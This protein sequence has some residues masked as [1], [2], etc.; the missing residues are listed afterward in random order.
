LDP[1]TAE[2]RGL[3]GVEIKK[4]MMWSSRLMRQ[5]GLAEVDERHDKAGNSYDDDDDDMHWVK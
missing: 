4:T 2:V 5:S 3:L 1:L